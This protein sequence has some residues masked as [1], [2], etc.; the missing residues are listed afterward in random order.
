[1]SCPRA[2]ELNMKGGN[3]PKQAPD[4]NNATGTVDQH[5]G[6]TI[7]FFSGQPNDDSK[8]KANTPP[9][10]EISSA[11]TTRNEGFDY[12]GIILSSLPQRPHL[13]HNHTR[14]HQDSQRRGSPGSHEEDYRARYLR[15]LNRNKRNRPQT[16]KICNDFY[17]TGGHCSRGEYCSFTHI[18]PHLSTDAKFKEYHKKCAERQKKKQRGGITINWADGQRSAAASEAHVLTPQK[19]KIRKTIYL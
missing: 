5:V 16:D 13:H 4:K 2:F 3:T 19:T 10:S 14:S 6:R 15:T 1:M 7:E 8:E 18:V 12:S 11:M 9:S 17:F